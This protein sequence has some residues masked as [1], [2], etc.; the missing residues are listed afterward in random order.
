MYET[1][2]ILDTRAAKSYVEAKMIKYLERRILI[3]PHTYVG[4]NGERKTL[5]QYCEILLRTKGYLF[6]FHITKY[7]TEISLL[8]LRMNFFGK[9]LSFLHSR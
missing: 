5:S 3:K 4:Y 1:F 6:F 2:V 8:S 7:E 9:F